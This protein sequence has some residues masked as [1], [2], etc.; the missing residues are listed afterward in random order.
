MFRKGVKAPV[1]EAAYRH[2]F[3]TYSVN[4]FSVSTNYPVYSIIRYAVDLRKLDL[5]E[6]GSVGLVGIPEIRGGGGRMVRLLS[7]KSRRRR[8]SRGLRSGQGASGSSLYCR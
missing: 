6:S 2:K 5:G 3:V 7:C 8:I 4:C 1:I